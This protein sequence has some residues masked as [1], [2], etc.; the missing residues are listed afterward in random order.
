MRA[1]SE[2]APKRA[3]EPYMLPMSHITESPRWTFKG[4]SGPSKFNDTPG[5]GSYGTLAVDPTSRYQ[6]GPRYGFGTSN[7]DALSRPKVPGPG[8]Y[9]LHRGNVEKNG[10]PMTKMTPRRNPDTK[11]KTDVP[12]PGAHEIKSRFGEGP[13]FSSP[14]YSD[15]N[16]LTFV[17]QSGPGPDRYEHNDEVRYERTPRWGF[18][19]CPRM[20]APGKAHSKTPGPGS[21]ATTIGKG[22]AISMKAR[23]LGTRTEPTPG[24]GQYGGHWT[25]FRR[26]D[27]KEKQ[28]AG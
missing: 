24:P 2:G 19:T 7:R 3:E 27:V 25:Q 20:D 5:P 8:S 28:A 23:P 10:S 22:P 21:L 17:K 9:Q 1:S 18:G 14:N 15:G 4:S 16:R 12:G 11:V 13:S 26:K 6:R